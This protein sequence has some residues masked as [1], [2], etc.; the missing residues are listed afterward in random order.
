M[1]VFRKYRDKNGNPTGPW[2]IQYPVQRDPATGKIRYRTKKASWQKKKAEQMFRKKHDEFQEREWLGVTSEPDLTFNQLIKWGLELEVMKAKA[3]TSDDERTALHL[4]AH[5]GQHKAS[6]ITPVMVDNFRL[7]MKRTVSERTGKPYS[8]TTINK[9]VTL[10]RRIYYLGMDA[11][12]VTQNPFARRGVFKE[13]PKG[14]YIPDE[15][16]RKL[17]EFLPDYLKPVALTAYLT[18]MRR[19]EILSLRWEQVDLFKG[20]ID[21][22]SADT[23]TDEPRH[24][25]FGSLSELK[26]VFIEA[27]RSQNPGQ[28]SVFIKPDGNRVPKWYI[29]RL[30][31]K[32]CLQAEVGPYRFHDLRHTFNTNMVKAGVPEAVIM[33]LT[34][35]KTLAMFTR[36]THLDKE[37]GD[38]AMEKLGGLLAGKRGHVSKRA[39]QSPK[40]EEQ[41]G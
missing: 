7:Q 26:K 12:K 2:F 34:G 30:F 5:F 27:A 21:L 11:G 3:T 4:K 31:K 38:A 35:H 41:E 24:I 37:Q 20:L 14:Q 23:K 29:E 18:G 6:L 17:S 25:F 8:G 39:A 32:A 13:L 36:Y 15:E 9:M 19:G 1:G 16:F 40:K 22:S 10:A 33:K 28:E